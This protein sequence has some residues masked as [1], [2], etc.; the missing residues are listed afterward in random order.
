MLLALD[1]AV[2]S[3]SKAHSCSLTDNKT[4]QVEIY[5]NEETP[6]I[7]SPWQWTRPFGRSVSP[8]IYMES[9]HTSYICYI[10]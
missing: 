10:I 4:L 8:Y 9:K 7:P 6:D 2:K 3:K 1:N 5:L